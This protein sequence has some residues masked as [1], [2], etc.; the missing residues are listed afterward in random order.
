MGVGRKSYYTRAKELGLDVEI[1]Y[2]IKEYVDNAKKP[3]YHGCYQYIQS[4]YPKI[5][6]IKPE[7]IM[8]G[9]DAKAIKSG[10][11]WEYAYRSTHNCLLAKSELLLSKI[12]EDDG[13]S[14]KNRLKA[15]EIVIKH[16][17]DLKQLEQDKE[18]L[19]MDTSIIFGYKGS[20]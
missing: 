3:T 4:K 7:N 16:D 14:S 20:K 8:Y 6:F 9:N 10:K 11:L 12:L 13:E 1:A 2:A 15:A 19:G 18:F 5:F 17:R